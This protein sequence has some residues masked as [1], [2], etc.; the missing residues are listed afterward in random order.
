MDMLPGDQIAAAGLAE[1][2]KLAQGLHARYRVGSFAEAARFVA[3]V[4]EVGDEVG[5]HPR[6]RIGSGFV[7]LELVTDDAI[8]RTDDG[9]EYVVEWPTQQDVDLAR[10]ISDVAA[11]HGLVADPAAVAEVELGLEVA[12]SAAVAP[13]WA[14]LLTGDATSQGRG[15]PGDEVR[16]GTQRV[17]NLWFDDP[18]ADNGG[19]RWHVEVYVAASA[20]EERL[21]A[22]LAAGATVVDDS[23]A[24]GLTVIADQ[25]GN[26]G[27]ICVT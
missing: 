13:V 6:V 5:H 8:Y 20:R 21:A 12:D 23:Q 4:G 19:Q 3:A 16:D 2:V 1:W 24:P 14:A 10:R 25:E 26:R 7:D 18:R 11:N 15:S 27:V 17:P 9:T 22:A